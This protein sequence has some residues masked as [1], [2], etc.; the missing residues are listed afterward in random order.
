M[1]ARVLA[2]CLLVVVLPA[3][4]ATAQTPVQ[5]VVDM[6]PAAPGIQNFLYIPESALFSTRAEV[7][8]RDPLRTR[9]FYSIGYIGGIDRGIG[10]GHVPGNAHGVVLSVDP[11]GTHAVNPGNTAYLEPEGAIQEMFAGPEVQ[12]VEAGAAAPAVI[13]AAPAAPAFAAEIRIGIMWPHDRFEFFLVDAVTVWRGG[14]GGAFSTQQP[15]NS[16]DTGGD[17]IPDATRTL[18]GVDPDPP[19]PVPPAAFYV[20][21]IDGPPATGPAWLQVVQLGDVNCDQ[22]FNFDDINAFV[23]LIPPD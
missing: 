1:S 15:I 7:W 10:F 12:Y 8:I 9:E 21:Y 4:G 6:N 11:A 16:L 17:Y 20:D 23:E 18:Y 13:P 22:S 14:V 3:A 5:V 2:A 19:A